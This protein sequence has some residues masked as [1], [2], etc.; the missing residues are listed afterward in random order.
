MRFTI[1]RV[2]IAV[3]VLA[4]LM[5][6]GIAI[7]RE[8][9]SLTFSETPAEWTW[10][11]V[12]YLEKDHV[13]D[14]AWKKAA[15]RKYR[16]LAREF[17]RSGEIRGESTYCGPFSDK[18][19]PG[20]MVIVPYATSAERSDMKGDRTVAGETWPIAPT[21]V[22]QVVKDWAGDEDDCSPLRDIAVRLLD[23]RH[24]GEIG[25][26]ERIYLRRK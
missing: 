5:G 19:S 8:I 10:K 26:V 21:S 4:V 18:L 13:P 14:E 3:A 23:G 11:W 20:Q 9:R 22:L 2:M 15:I 17:D 25:K 16:E 24:K 6:M 1:R 12:A 7:D